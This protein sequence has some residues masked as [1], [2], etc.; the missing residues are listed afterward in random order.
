MTEE[1]GASDSGEEDR[2]ELDDRCSSEDPEEYLPD[3]KRKI[4]SSSDKT[5]P[6]LRG[7]DEVAVE[8][9]TVRVQERTKR[10]LDELMEGDPAWKALVIR[11]KCLRE[12][13]DYGA[14]Y[15][16]LGETQVQMESALTIVH[17]RRGNLWC[18]CVR[19]CYRVVCN[20]LVWFPCSI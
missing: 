12:V 19:V 13:F 10:R 4:V 6:I 9:P 16:I 11:D 20:S 2:A 1:E 15:G 17:G 7:M 14:V 8:D 18:F 3:L 5:C